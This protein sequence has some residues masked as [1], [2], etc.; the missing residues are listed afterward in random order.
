MPYYYHLSFSDHELAKPGQLL[1]VTGGG[2]YK[3]ETLLCESLGV[4]IVHQDEM[5]TLV[6]GL[7]FVLNKDEEL[8]CYNYQTRAKEF[9]ERE[10]PK[11]PVDGNQPDNPLYPFLIVNI[12]SGVSIINAKKPG[13]YVR[14]SGTCVGGGTVL[15]LARLLIGAKDFD[16]VTAL[17]AAGSPCLDMTVADLC[18]DAAGSKVLP[19]ETLASSFGRV[20]STHEGESFEGIEHFNREDIARSLIEMVSYNLG[21]IAFLL[22][23]IHGLSRVIFSGKFI[24]YHEPTMGSITKGVN[25]YADH[26]A[27]LLD[28]VV[29]S[30]VSSAPKVLFIEHDGNLGAIG[31]LL[32][33]IKQQASMDP[34]IAP[35]IFLESPHT[36]VLLPRQ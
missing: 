16:E 1:T 20:Y 18:G 25:F 9:I 24:T 2:A 32:L 7:G 6:T 23:Q 5:E 17:S 36:Q 3:F 28:S 14:V 13:D 4:S 34:S 29:Y 11:E 10:E 30:N 15:G 19:P 27:Q 22:C 35:R 12:G 33:L 8:Y 31:A 26:Y 21:Y